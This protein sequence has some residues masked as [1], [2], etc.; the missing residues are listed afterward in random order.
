[1]KKIGLATLLLASVLVVSGCGNQEPSKQ[2]SNSQK[3]TKTV[4]KRKKSNQPKE[5]TKKSDT[6]WDS[7]KDNQLEAF[8]DQWGPTMK[9]SYVKYDGKNS[10]KI[11]TGMVYPDDLSRVT[12]EGANASI[13]W[14]KDGK[15]TNEYDV[16]AIYNYNGVVPPL[17]NHITYFFAFHNDQPIVLVDQS[18]NGTPNLI[19]T[20]NTKLKSGFDDIVAGKKA[21]VDSDE[22][23]SQTTSQSKTGQLTTDPK[24][25]GVMVHQLVFPGD[26]VSKEPLGIYTD[27]GNYWIGIGTAVTTVGYEIN[28]NTVSYYTKDYSGGQSTADAPLLKHDIQLSELE[29]K[30][31]STDEQKQGVQAI[32]DKMPAIDSQ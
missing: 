25:V 29:N 9:Q 7:T 26:D 21:T 8:M 13:D 18:T 30:Y 3:T 6:L 23:S 4:V 28:G 10:L 22:T 16:V 11:S 20:G 32:A 1:M 14:S 2:S 27:G 15:G 12:V 19:E 24:M 17:P 5:S 31:Y